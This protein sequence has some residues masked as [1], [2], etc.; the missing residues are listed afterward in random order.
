MR[1]ERAGMKMLG[2]IE[3]LVPRHRAPGAGT[4]TSAISLFHPQ[5]YGNP[6][7]CAWPP[8]APTWCATLLQTPSPSLPAI[9]IGAAHHVHGSP[10]MP[11]SARADRRGQGGLRAATARSCRL[12]EVHD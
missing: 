7:F 4:P 1:K 5:T 3:F 6:R 10:G 11:L 2:A 12:E 8:A 9:F